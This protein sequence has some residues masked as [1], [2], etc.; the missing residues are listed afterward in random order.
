MLLCV[1]K[2]MLFCVNKLML[3]C[4]LLSYIIWIILKNSFAY[5]YKLYQVEI[6]W[7]HT[8]RFNLGKISLSF[9]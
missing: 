3:F 5:A 2:L 4:V 1:N 6:Y 9:K 8:T 7:V